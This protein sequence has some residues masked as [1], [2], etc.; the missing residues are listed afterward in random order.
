M[1]RPRID[2]PFVLSDLKEEATPRRASIALLVVLGAATMGISFS[3]EC[4]HSSNSGNSCP[5][6]PRD[7]AF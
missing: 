1:S 3:G 4:S 7:A 5:W 6:C 2:L